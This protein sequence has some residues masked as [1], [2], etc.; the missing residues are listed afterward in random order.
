MPIV[1]KFHIQPSG[2]SGKKT[3]SNGLDHITN[4]A[5]M[6]IYGKNFKKSSSTEP[7]YRWP[8]NLVYSIVYASTTKIVQIITLGWPWPILRQGQIWLH[9]LLHGQKWKLWVFLEIIAAIGLKVGSNIK[10]NEIMK[11]MYQRS[12]SLFDLGHRSLRF[13]N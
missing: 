2:P 11:L 12:R 5:A 8:W 9:R 6:P 13:Q 1:T 4:M 7:I 3:Y 10:M